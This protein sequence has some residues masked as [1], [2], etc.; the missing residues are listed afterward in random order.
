VAVAEAAGKGRFAFELWKREKR[1]G[2]GWELE[3]EA[4]TF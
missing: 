1:G 2:V 3:S 4:K